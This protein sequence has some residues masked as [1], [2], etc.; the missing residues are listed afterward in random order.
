MITIDEVKKL[1]GLAR[2]DISEKEA[3]AFANDMEAILEYVDTVK[4][5]AGEKVE[6]ADFTVKNVLREDVVSESSEYRNDILKNAPR[7]SNDFIEVKKVLD[8]K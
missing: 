6:Q 5:V 8:A 7:I 2:I 4:K 3:E 1:A